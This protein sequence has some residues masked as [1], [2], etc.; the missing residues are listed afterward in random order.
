[1]VDVL[2]T[3]NVE[4]S[5]PLAIVT[6]VGDIAQVTGLVAPAGDVVTAQLSPTEPV[7]PFVGFTEIV[8]VLPLVAPAVMLRSPLL[9]SVNPGVVLVAPVT[10]AVKPRVWI[11]CP[12][13]SAAVIITL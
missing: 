10:I 11:Y 5:A 13:E 6:D 4:T 3:V 9:L 1:V 12:V 2:L 8:E 7:N